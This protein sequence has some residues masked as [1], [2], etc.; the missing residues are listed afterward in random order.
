MGPARWAD[1]IV[2]E[3]QGVS[4]SFV[5]QISK[6]S[7][8]KQAPKLRGYNHCQPACVMHRTCVCI[9][10][11]MLRR[12]ASS[13]SSAAASAA[14]RAAREKGQDLENRVKR[15][16]ELEGVKPVR[17]N[18]ILKD[19]FGNRSEI[20]LVAGKYRKR[21]VE[22]KNYGSS[23]GAGNGGSGSGSSSGSGSGSS[24][25]LEDVAKFKAV[26]E[27]HNIPLSRGLF[28][29]T[30]TYSPRAR[31]IGVPT[32]DGEGLRAWEAAAKRSRTF[33]RVR[34]VLLAL[35]AC[36][37]TLVGI[38]P[39]VEKEYAGDKRNAPLSL[40]YALVLN[41]SFVD[42]YR[43][44]RLRRSARSGLFSSSSSSSQE[45]PDEALWNALGQWKPSF[46]PDNIRKEIDGRLNQAKN[47]A[48]RAIYRVA[49][50]VT[51]ALAPSL[52]SPSFPSSSASSA[53]SHATSAP[54]RASSSWWSSSDDSDDNASVSSSV[55]S[56]RS[57]VITQHGTQAAPA[58]ASK[59]LKAAIALTPAPVAPRYTLADV[60]IPPVVIS[61][62]NQT[63]SFCGAAARS[64]DEARS[65]VMD[66]VAQT[67]DFIARTLE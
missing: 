16:F 32:V 62:L 61:S 7:E 53:A 35:L 17:T 3:Q 37:V 8:H 4:A 54:A 66:T 42:G 22:C 20:D 5:A 23:G 33:R 63:G 24:V 51:D 58:P 13:T 50:T 60:M 48:A 57:K 55:T 44:S 45:A 46:L 27:L 31:T 10:F 11:K 49:T 59:P 29:T 64:L 36:G 9:S 67:V 2:V 26:L 65:F 25:P 1:R 19:R 39:R 12:F 14:G 6:Q 15:I 43:R 34:R 41:E 21:Y 52:P 38:S 40:L 56:I 47:V 30:S 18:V 28:V